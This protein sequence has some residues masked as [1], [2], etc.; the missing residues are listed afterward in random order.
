[1]ELSTFFEQAWVR[2][3]ALCPDADRVRALL[4][5]RGDVWINDHVAFRT[6]DLPGMTR[7]ELGRPFEALGYVLQKD[8]MIFTEK[9][10]VANF[11][12]HPDPKMPK[13]FISELRTELVSQPLQDWIRH[14]TEP[15]YVNGLKP[16][17]ELFLSPTWNPVKFSDF[18]RFYAESEYAAWTAAFGIQVNHYTVLV[19]EL[20]SLKSLQELNAFLVENRFE[21]N[22]AGGVVKGTPAEGLEQSSTRGRKIPAQFELDSGAIGTQEVMGCYVEFARRHALPG[23]PG[24]YAGFIP[25]SADKIFESTY[26]RKH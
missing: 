12:L 2:Y 5:K 8:D 17:L 14:V 16:S 13:V 23:R 9:K 15:F 1:M 3:N 10:L 19:N 21:L 18:Q 4:E 26:E 22:D 11:W 6:F 20:K 24:L 7:L 25:A